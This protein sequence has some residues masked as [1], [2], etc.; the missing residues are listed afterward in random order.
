M[1]KLPALLYCLRYTHLMRDSIL[2][3]L[4]AWYLWKLIVLR[5]MQVT[6]LNNVV[7]PDGAP[8]DEEE[9]EEEEGDEDKDEE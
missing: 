4:P 3:Y 9:E 5:M 8:S 1:L 7:M 6:Y 2:S